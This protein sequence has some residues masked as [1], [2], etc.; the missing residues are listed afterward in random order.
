MNFAQAFARL[1]E[2]YPMDYCILECTAVQNRSNDVMVRYR[3]YTSNPKPRW[4]E[5]ETDPGAAVACLDPYKFVIP[6]NLTI[7]L[8]GAPAEK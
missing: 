8:E 1:R 2:M 7:T 3:A 4:D 5:F 6:D